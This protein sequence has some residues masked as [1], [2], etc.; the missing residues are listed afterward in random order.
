MATGPDHSADGGRDWVREYAQSHQHP[1]NRLCHTLGI[2]I[3]AGSLVLVPLAF[4]WPELWVWFLALQ[5]VGWGLQFVGHAIEGKAPEFLRDPRF[6]FVGL[7]WWWAK[8]RGE[9]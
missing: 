3:I 4:S 6:L 7:R 9:V 1:L 5:G 8:V 2:P